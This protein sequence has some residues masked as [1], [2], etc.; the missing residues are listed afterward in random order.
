MNFEIYTVMAVSLEHCSRR[1]MIRVCILLQLYRFG[2]SQAL[3]L[4][5]YQFRQARFCL[6]YDVPAVAG[7]KTCSDDCTVFVLDTTVANDMVHPHII[8]PSRKR[9]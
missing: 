2:V 4:I 1:N 8:C 3:Y 6:C 9:C 5:V 7:Y